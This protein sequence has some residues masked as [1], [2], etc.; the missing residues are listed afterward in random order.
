VIDGIN[1]ACVVIDDV[2]ALARETERLLKL[3]DE[4]WRRMSA[5]AFET[6]SDLSWDRS[7]ALFEQA[8]ERVVSRASA[9]SGAQLFTL[10]GR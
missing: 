4:Q 5:N 7:A 10:N 9:D 6:T 1:G 8:L 3:P 2:D